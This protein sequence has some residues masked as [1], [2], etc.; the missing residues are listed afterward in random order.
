MTC[1]NWSIT[2]IIPLSLVLLPCNVEAV[3]DLINALYKKVINALCRKGT[4]RLLLGLPT[5]S[6]NKGSPP[7]IS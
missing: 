7:I 1:Y 6:L 3:H 2:S 5:L 4:Y